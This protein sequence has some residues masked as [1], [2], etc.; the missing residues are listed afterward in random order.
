MSVLGRS[1][2]GVSVFDLLAAD[3]PCT[4]YSPRCAHRSSHVFLHIRRRFALRFSVQSNIFTAANAAT[5]RRCLRR[6]S[7]ICLLTCPRL[8]LT[9]D[10]N[11][12]NSREIL[13]ILGCVAKSAF[14]KRLWACFF[15]LKFLL[16]ISSPDLRF[17]SSMKFLIWACSVHLNPSY[18]LFALH[19]QLTH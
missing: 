9:L 15:F 4:E 1:V 17:V 2:G 13:R 5:Q 3:S 18:T 16:N 14:D 12:V 8:P 11:I 19:S 10:R 6:R 7:M